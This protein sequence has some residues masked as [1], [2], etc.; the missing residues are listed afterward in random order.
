MEEREELV[1]REL[2]GAEALG[3]E[4]LLAPETVKEAEVVPA[5]LTVGTREVDGVAVPRLLR[6]GEPD[7][8]GHALTLGHALVDPPTK[9]FPAASPCVDCVGLGRVVKEAVSGAEAEAQEGVDSPVGVAPTAW[10]EPVGSDEP[11]TVGVTEFP[12]DTL[13]DR[14]TLEVTVGV[15]V[16]LGEAEVL[17]V[18]ADVGV[19]RTVAVALP[20]VP[21]GVKLPVGVAVGVS[22]KE[23]RV[24]GVAVV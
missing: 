17:K 5:L 12:G 6:E 2:R 20:P 8:E 16:T 19:A 23:T 1:E 3:V 9:P 14:V 21:V 22:E 18:A 24:L 10:G 7:E 4:L 15:L 13:W 11:D